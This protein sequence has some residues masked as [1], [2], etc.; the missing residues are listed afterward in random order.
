MV[1]DQNKSN[2]LEIAHV[3]FMDLV[4]YSKLLIDEQTQYLNQ[5]QEIVRNTEEFCRAL[6]RNQLIS[7]PTGDGMALVFFGD[8]VAPVR[9][10]LEISHALH[11]YPK[12]RLRMGIHSGLVDRFADINANMNVTG[13]GINIA[14]RVMDCGDAGHIL[15]SK[16]VAEDL[17]QLSGWAESLHDLGEVEVKHQLK[18]QIFNL[19]TDEVG[20]AQRPVKTCSE[21]KPDNII[22]CQF[23]RTVSYLPLYVA[24]QKGYFLAE[25]LTVTIIDANGDDFTWDK[26]KCDEAQFGIADPFM[27]LE[28]ANMKGKVISTIVSRA[29]LWGITRKSIAPI[30]DFKELRGRVIAVYKSPSTSFMMIN[31][32]LADHQLQDSVVIKQMTPGSEYSVLH[33]PDVDVV[34]VPEPMVSVSELKDAHVVFS[35]AKYFGDF[36]IT[37]LFVTEKYI[38]EYPDVVQKVV[39]ALERS[40]HFLRSNNVNALRVAAKEFT[41]LPKFAIEKATLRLLY[42]NVI[43]KHTTVLANSWDSCLQVRRPNDSASFPFS[44]FVDNSFALRAVAKYSYK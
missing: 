27:I 31:R 25:G 14:Q 11:S 13:G 3:L 29:A 15:L 9:C 21:S 32:I 19:Y 22:I 43:P 35:S 17:C 28:E 4:G 20:N 24:Q 30:K 39:N 16:R 18:V 12:I 41:D 34:L 40:L 42:E 26:V 37:G 7:L 23:H 1:L 44:T 6:D 5:L 10:A 33:S 36:L 2:P 8:P 38:N